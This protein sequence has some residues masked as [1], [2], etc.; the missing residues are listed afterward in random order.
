MIIV[1]ADDWGGWPTA[2]NAIRTCFVA[3]R[4][5]S[6][7]AM[8]FM[9]DS[10]RAAGLALELGLD[11]GLHLNLNQD[12]SAAD[13]PPDVKARQARIGRFLKRSRYA[14]LLYHPFLRNDFRAVFAA[15]LAEFV[16]LYGRPPTHIDGHRHM[17]LSS[18]MLLD[19][20]IPAGLRVRRSFSFWPGE[21]S[22]L[23]RTYRRMV[24]RRLEKSY[25]V[26]RYFFALSQCAAGPRFARVV[27][28]ARTD[29]VELMT[30]PEMP[31]EYKF[32]LSDAF[33]DALRTLQ[34]G[35]YARI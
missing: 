25:R 27:E 1:N 17:H 15:Q 6:V 16:R 33:A 26:T 10:A 28:L 29:T 11:A 9:E 20:I 19:R 4:V 8:V 12:L 31:V 35:S 21:K 13:C 34:V 2:T 5:S 3:G 24:D 23:N 32:L 7:S 18:N 14:L 22:L 30:H